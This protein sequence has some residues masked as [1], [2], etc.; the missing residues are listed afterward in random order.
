MTKTP[1]EYRTPDP[2]PSNRLRAPAIFLIVIGGLTLLG[3]VIDF[4]HGIVGGARPYFN[5]GTREGAMFFDAASAVVLV[6]M[7]V[8]A[9]QMLRVRSYWIAVA[10]AILA[11]IPI[12]APCCNAFTLPFGIWALVLLANP[13]VNASFGRVKGGRC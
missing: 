7:I 5:W 10:A 3:L 9:I 6:P 1:L 12:P 4:I 11:L 8:G 13:E 2:Q